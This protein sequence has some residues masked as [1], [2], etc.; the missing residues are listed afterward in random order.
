MECEMCG[1]IKSSLKTVKI[2]ASQMNVCVDCASYGTRL[3]IN[4]KNNFSKPTFKPT[5]DTRIIRVDYASVIKKARENNNLKQSELAH[6]LNEK[7]SLMQSIESGHKKPSFQVAKKLQKFLRIRLIEEMPDIS[8]TNPT[9]TDAKPLTMEQK[10]LD[11]LKK[12]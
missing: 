6:R 8:P 2:D 9:S 12:N 11:A 10:V 1:K 4:K 7:E 5:E 3:E